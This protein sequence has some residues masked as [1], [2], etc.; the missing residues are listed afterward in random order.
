MYQLAEDHSFRSSKLVGGG[1]FP[2]NHTSVAQSRS[3]ISA[4]NRNKTQIKREKGR[5]CLPFCKCLSTPKGNGTLPKSHL[6]SRNHSSRWGISWDRRPL[7]A[8][9]KSSQ[10]GSISHRS[11]NMSLSCSP[12]RT[13]AGN[14]RGNKFSETTCKRGFNDV[15]RL[16]SRSVAVSKGKQ[17]ASSGPERQSAIPYAEA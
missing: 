4:A 14:N 13:Q 2:Q 15:S 1:D 12:M 6:L 8:Y 3:V 5:F 9:R 16:E 7:N 10:S 11:N 17:P